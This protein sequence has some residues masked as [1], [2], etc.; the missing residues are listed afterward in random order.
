M[1]DELEDVL[2]TLQNTP[3]LEAIKSSGSAWRSVLIS[4]LSAAVGALVGPFAWGLVVLAFS[5]GQSNLNLPEKKA[6]ELV[7]RL[8]SEK[9]RISKFHD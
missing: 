7:E 3:V 9:N 1:A 5:S 2:A 8:K 6:Q 4:L